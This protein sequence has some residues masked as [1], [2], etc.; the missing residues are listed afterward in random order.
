MG[1]ALINVNGSS[2][3]TLEILFLITVISLLPSIVIMMTSFT[4]IIISLSFL[5]SAIGVQQTPP[6]S[7]LIGI[8]LFLTLFIMSPVVDDINKNAYTPYKNEQITQEEALNRAVVPLKDFMLK[9]TEKSSL[10]M[11]MEF[12]GTEYPENEEEL[13]EK[14]SLRVV[15][16][17]FITSEL[18]KAFT[19]GFLLFIPFLLIDIVVSSTLMSMG[20]IMLPPSLISLP[21]KVLLFVSVDG[22]QLLFSTLVRGFN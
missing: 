13:T 2:V 16:P 15:T 20:M 4:R 6:N 5:R 17:A 14:L 3:Q 9:Q 8:A 7:V 18:K 10:Q 22:W 12:S 21:F 11:F 19:I 1:E